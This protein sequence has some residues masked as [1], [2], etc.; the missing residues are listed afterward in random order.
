MVHIDGFTSRQGAVVSSLHAPA[1]WAANTLDQPHA[2]DILTSEEET[3][4]GSLSLML[5][6]FSVVQ[7]KLSPNR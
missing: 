5:Q 6:P 2:V 1:P 4:S 3:R 7:I